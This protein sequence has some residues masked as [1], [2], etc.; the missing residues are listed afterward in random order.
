MK[1]IT[2][3]LHAHRMSDIVHA[4]EARAVRREGH[5]LGPAALRV[6]EQLASVIDRQAAQPRR[7]ETARELGERE[8]G[9][10][11]GVERAPA[12]AVRHRV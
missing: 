3:L 4:L 5:Q 12:A 10:R 2:A 7:A 9:L 8:G 6:V 11:E 1:R